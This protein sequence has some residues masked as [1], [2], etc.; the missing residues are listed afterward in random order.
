[1][2][3]ISYFFIL[4]FVIRLLNLLCLIYDAYI[5]SDQLPMSDAFIIFENENKRNISS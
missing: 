4:S 5:F 3:S 1:M 2:L